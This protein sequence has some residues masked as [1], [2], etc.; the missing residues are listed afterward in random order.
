M[1]ASIRQRDRSGRFV[2]VFKNLIPIVIPPAFPL[3]SLSVSI[4]SHDCRILNYLSRPSPDPAADGRPAWE[5]VSLAA[6][7][8]AHSHSSCAGTRLWIWGSVL[9]RDWFLFLLQFPPPYSMLLKEAAL[10]FYISL[11]PLVVA[12]GYTH[13]GNIHASRM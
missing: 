8:P 9:Q 5:W 7:W 6:R 10:T 12:D 1:D 4:L 3:S 2:K 13:K 11:H